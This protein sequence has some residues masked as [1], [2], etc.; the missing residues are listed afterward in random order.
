MAYNH[1]DYCGHGLFLEEGKFRVAEVDDG[2][3]WETLLAFDSRD[4]FSA[5]LA[6]QSDHSLNGY[7]GRGP[8][9][10]LRHGNNQRITR[11][12]LEQFIGERLS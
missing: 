4:E 8:F 6:E 10:D 3:G 2:V 11:A 1:R 7:T 12:R 9:E 5:W